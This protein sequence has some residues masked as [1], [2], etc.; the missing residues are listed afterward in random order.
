MENRG[1]LARLMAVENITVEHRNTETASFDV[2]NRVL[3][4][5]TW[6]AMSPELY[7][8][9]RAHEVGHALETPAQGWHGTVIADRRLKSF[10][11]VVEDARIERLIKN[12]FPGLRPSFV[13]G[14]KELYDQDFF[15]T[16]NKKLDTLLLVDRINLHFKIGSHLNVPFDDYEQTIVDRV[17]QA[18]TWD[19]VVALAKEIYDFDAEEL[20][21]QIEES[22]DAQRML[23]D[24]LGDSEYDEDGEGIESEEEAEG[25]TSDERHKV[26]GNGASGNVHT[27]GRKV[28]D[29]WY[30][31]KSETDGPES[32][33]DTIFRQRETELLDEKTLP[34]IYVDVPT[35]NLDNIIVPHKVVADQFKFVALEGAEIDQHLKNNLKFPEYK[36][37]FMLRNSRFVDHMVREF[38]I[39]RNARQMA[40]AGSAKTGALNLKKVHQYKLTDDLF[41]RL[42]VVPKGKSHGMIM[43]FDQSG[44]M[45][46]Y[47]GQT[48][49]QI[50]VLSMFC[51][52]INVP[53]HVYGFTDNTDHLPSNVRYVERESFSSNVGEIAFH[54]RN[55]FTLREYFSHTQTSTEFKAMVDRVLILAASWRRRISYMVSMLPLSERLCGTPLN[56]AIASLIEMV[57]AFKKAH[58]LDIVNTILLTDG[59]SNNA[60]SAFVANTDTTENLR[61]K[62]ANYVHRYA[63]STYLCFRHKASKLEVQTLT[64]HDNRDARTTAALLRLMSSITGARTIG[65]FISE[66]HRNRLR[67]WYK[68]NHELSNPTSEEI[69]AESAALEIRK[70]GYW[71]SKDELLTGYKNYFRVSGKFLDFKEESLEV[72]SANTKDL[73]KAFAKLH[74]DKRKHRLLLSNFIEQI[75]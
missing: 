20:K 46:D 34:R 14:Y 53:F 59:E 75:A 4:L 31:F 50:V 36:A 67:E 3:T 29:D 41:Q 49:E 8:M 33:T 38:E 60:L 18:R 39:K 42:T 24:G 19:D 11:N 69:F 44:S 27:P 61:P 26:G 30:E 71:L 66:G 65:Y 68:S 47:Y 5:P 37:D 15:G 32:M 43:M 70:H 55:L 22:L 16:A 45:G 52:K 28:L 35:A 25:E 58:R 17:A 72:D 62:T 10:L 73:R 7:D 48:L 57:P 63:G 54:G 1:I 40:R 6:K 64:H 21:R 23:S 74:G 56:E 51:R 13:K 12:R 2:L 9:L